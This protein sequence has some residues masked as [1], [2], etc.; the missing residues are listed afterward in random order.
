MTFELDTSGVVVI[1]REPEGVGIRYGWSDLLPFDQGFTRAA[2][3]SVRADLDQR[4]Y[5]LWM[6]V[7]FRH[8]HPA[9]LAR[10][11]KDCAEADAAGAYER[12]ERGGALF[13]ADVQMGAYE[14]FRHY[15]LSP[16]PDGKI[17]IEEPAR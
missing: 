3:E 12:N 7:G 1:L 8:L 6:R 16:D 15:R 14:R 17:I 2:L 13:W 5:G 4:R 10:F 11:L 9:T